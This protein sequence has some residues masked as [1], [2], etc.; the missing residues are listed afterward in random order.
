MAL[1]REEIGAR[2]GAALYGFGQDTNTL[3]QIHDEM[4][5]LKT[6]LADNPRLVDVF[7]DPVYSATEKSELLAKISADFC[8]QVQ[9]FLKLLLEYNRFN[10]LPEIVEQFNVYYNRSKNIAYGIATSAVA[11]DD[12]QLNR[13]S[14]AYASK[15]GLKKLYLTNEVDSSLIGGV[16][17]QVED[18]VIDGSVKTKLKKIRAQLI[19]NI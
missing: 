1:S 8:A 18:Y 6:A 9:E 7:T 15:H 11:L 19:D 13:L 2:Y 5:V 14:E 17:L 4:D 12:E 3:E 10:V 16:I